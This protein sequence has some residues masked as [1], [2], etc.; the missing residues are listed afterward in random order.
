MKAPLYPPPLKKGDTIGVIAPAGQL[1][2]KS[3]FMQGVTILQ[4]MGFQVKYPLN[5]W[6]GREYLA[7]SDDNRGDEFNRLIQDE[8]IDGLIALRGGYGCLRM[9]E[10][11]DLSLVTRNP[12]ILTGFSDITILQNFLYLQTGLISLHGPVVTSLHGATK[13]TLSSF[14]DRLTIKKPPHITCKQVEVLRYGASFAAPLIGGNLASLVT[15]LGTP[16]DFSWDHKIVFLEDINEPM[17][18]I[19]R[20][21]TQLQLAGKLRKVAGLILGDFSTSTYLDQTEKLCYRNAIWDRVLELCPTHAVPIWGNFPSGHCACNLS[22]PL[23]AVAEMD[24]GAI[25]LSFQ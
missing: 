3:R 8:E 21:L 6:P 18:K 13:D 12:K 22:F 11:I 7:D 9:L 24:S 23:G 5:L 2:D 1:Q 4:E 16:Y 20:M 10:K 25:K 15:L 14:Y 17:Y 19:D